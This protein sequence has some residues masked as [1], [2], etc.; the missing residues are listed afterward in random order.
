MSFQIET[1]N[2]KQYTSNV[3]HLSQQ[4]GSR[5]RNFVRSESQKSEAAFYD[6]IGA[7]TAQKKVGRHSDTT[8]QD[9]P[10]SRR[11]VTLEDYFYSDLVDEED[12]LR[13]IMSPESEY[14]KAGAMALGRAM[15]E[16]IIDAA[17]GT[18]STG[19]EGAGS[20]AL[21]ASQQLAAFDGSTLT[22][23]RLNVQTLRAV[24]KKFNANEVREG[25]LYFAITAE[26]LDGLLGETEVTSS[27]FN[28]VKAL[29]QGDVDSFMGFKFI[30]TELLRSSAAATTYDETDGSV[31]AGAATLP[32]GADRCFA[33]KKDGILLA[34][35][36]DIMGRID[37]MPG[38]HYAHQVY[39]KMGLGAVRMEEA[40]VVEVLCLVP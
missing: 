9:T 30:R 5:L 20:Q 10:H 31:G 24:K 11:R 38:K 1:A 35:A 3:F 7:V 28:S 32:A 27:D 29:V 8:Y 17:L 36:K 19:K 14:A 2:V 18:A 26:Q 21:G 13:I 34:I 16:V 37:E 4:E 23:N 40:K 22:G 6:R 33:W 15:D 25:D 39:A 12:K